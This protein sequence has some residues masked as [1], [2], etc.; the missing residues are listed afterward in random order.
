[1]VNLISRSGTIFAIIDENEVQIQDQHKAKV[2]I[3]NN[4]RVEK[5][6]F[7]LDNGSGTTDVAIISLAQPVD[8]PESKAWNS[9]EN[10]VKN[11]PNN[12]T[13]NPPKDIEVYNS[14]P[15]KQ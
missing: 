13:P 15:P 4:H 1:M 7:W 14:K 6:M 8:K 9:W 11:C 10:Y 5:E 3:W 12:L 2:L